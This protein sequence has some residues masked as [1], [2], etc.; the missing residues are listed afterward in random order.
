MFINIAICDDEDVI[1]SKLEVLLQKLAAEREYDYSIDIYNDGRKL[2]DAVKDNVYDLIFLDIEMPVMNGI[3][4]ANYIHDELGNI[5]A[6][7]A[8]ISS[9]DGYFRQ[10]LNTQLLGFVDKPVDYD[11]IS[12]IIDKYIRYYKK[13]L[14]IFTYSKKGEHI[15]TYISDI[16]C[17]ERMGK[18]IRIDMIKESDEIYGLMDDIYSMVKANRFLYIH[19]S[20]IVNYDYIRKLEYER[21]ILHDGREFSI[22]QSRRKEIREKVMQIAKEDSRC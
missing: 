13:K 5:T 2:C 19:K 7:I 22:S 14:T 1:C 6:K 11:K 15:N 4:V 17:F 12:D 3:E 21:V 8:F 20:V 18:K 16:I 10:L 9:K